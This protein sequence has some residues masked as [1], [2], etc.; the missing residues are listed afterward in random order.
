[1]AAI[2]SSFE[3]RHAAVSSKNVCQAQWPTPNKGAPRLTVLPHNPGYE[4]D[5]WDYGDTRSNRCGDIAL[6]AL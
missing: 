3:I 6:E 2:T 1:M 4:K 5:S